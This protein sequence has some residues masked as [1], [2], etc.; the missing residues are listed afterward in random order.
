MTQLRRRSKLQPFLVF[1]IRHVS[2]LSL[3]P[4]E[5]RTNNNTAQPAKGTPENILAMYEKVFE[6]TM[7]DPAVKKDLEVGKGVNIQ[8]KNRKAYI[9]YL[10]ENQ[11]IITG[12]A[13]KVG[14]Y[15]RKN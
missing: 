9:N 13:K 14:L 12:A 6:K 7:N 4:R 5:W 15:K 1:P 2:V 11:K 8:F 10:K 3:K